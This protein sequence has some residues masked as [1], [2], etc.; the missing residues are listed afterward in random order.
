M[1]HSYLISPRIKELIEEELE[2]VEEDNKE[3]KELNAQE[4]EQETP[5]EDLM[6]KGQK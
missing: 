1:N 5:E 2:V 6:E 4:A 3:I